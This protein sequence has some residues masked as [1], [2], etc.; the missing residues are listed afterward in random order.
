MLVLHAQRSFLTTR[1]YGDDA[2]SRGLARR[3][4]RDAHRD[5][6]PQKRRGRTDKLPR[7]AARAGSQATATRSIPIPTM[8]L[9]GSKSIQPAGR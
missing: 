5:V 8:L 4:F 9:V 7:A 1:R 2:A 6:H 3:L